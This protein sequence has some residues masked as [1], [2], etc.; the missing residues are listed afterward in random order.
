MTR[1]GTRAGLGSRSRDSDLPL[2]VYHDGHGTSHRYTG[3]NS[4]PIVLEVRHLGFARRPRRQTPSRGSRT[5]AE[6][7]DPRRVGPPGGGTFTDSMTRTLIHSSFDHDSRWSWYTGINS[8]PITQPVTSTYDSSDILLC[9][10]ASVAPTEPEHEVCQPEPQA[11]SEGRARRR[12]GGQRDRARPGPG[13]R[14]RRD[15]V[16]VS[17][18]PRAASG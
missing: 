12:A 15:S 17:R 16:R 2:E 5:R 14:A 11:D 7:A 9:E 1:P 6:A 18:A 4:G 10:S 8:G 3:I 13:R